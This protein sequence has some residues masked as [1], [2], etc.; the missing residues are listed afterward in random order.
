MEYSIHQLAALAG[1]T[2]RT[3]R[4]YDK[5]GLLRPCGRQDNGY[6]LYGSAEVDRLQQILFYRTLG[7]ELE[8]IRTI[9]DDPSFDALEALRGHLAALRERREHLDALISTVSE[10]IR[11]R[12]RSETMN[13][14]AK[15]AAFRRRE[16]EENEARYGAEVRSRYGDEAM[17]AA[18]ER[19]LR[20]TQE[21]YEA[22]T[23][24]EGEI[25]AAAAQAVKTKAAHDGEAGRE[26]A[27]LHRKWLELSL[28][29]QYS[30]ELHRNIVALYTA[31]ER[32]QAYYD[33]ECP[34]CAAFLQRAVLFWVQ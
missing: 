28:G 22:Y 11:A 31:D 32:F 26:L 12:E 6:R 7:V 30:P 2:T 29:K 19:R 14:E 20:M 15:L 8:Q 25:L 10:T 21:E 3:L 23:A 24:L 4:W 33:R 17:D 27:R 5:L 18:N 9:L 1:V 34:G 13:D 16:V